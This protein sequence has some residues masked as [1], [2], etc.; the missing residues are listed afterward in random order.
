MFIE[1][2]IP[3]DELR[4]FLAR[5]LPLTIRLDAAEVSH[6]LA[7]SDLA[8]VAIVPDVGVRLVCEA[9]L[10]WPVLGI[11]APLALNALRVLLIPEV[12]SSPAGESLVFRIAVEHVDIPGVPTVFDETIARAVNE[13]LA[14]HRVEV[15]WDFSR[16][17]ANVVPLP[18]MLVELDALTLG[19]AWGKVKITEEAL[20]FAVSVHAALARAGE[21]ESLTA[22]APSPPTFSERAK[23][24]ARDSSAPIVTLLLAAGVFGLAAGVAFFGLRLVSSR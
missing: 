8:E 22:P 9:H 5:A 2:L 11:D 10:H 7:L 4:S 15:P 3:R 20:V 19:A 18:S 23:P 12:K 21:A 24:V 13:R 17:F 14:A 6:F 1:A 16:T